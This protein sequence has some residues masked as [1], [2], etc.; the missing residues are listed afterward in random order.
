MVNGTVANNTTK[1]LNV[2]EFR[3]FALVDEKAPLIFINGADSWNAKFFSLLHEAAHIW[4]GRNDLYNDYEGDY[5]VGTDNKKI[6]ILCNKAASL[7]IASNDMFDLEW[8]HVDCKDVFET[9]TKLANVFHCSTTVIAR[10]ALDT[11]LITSHDYV[12]IAKTAKENYEMFRAKK[13]GGN[14]YNSQCVKLDR[15]FIYALNASVR[16][17][18]TSYTEAF[19]LTNTNGK[20]FARIVNIFED[21]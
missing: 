19:R 11:G 2:R 5:T 3:A 20:T 18:K 15:N 1:V 16:E 4:L 17:G 14:F 13:G 10:R 21:R 6:E 8:N 9:V 7:L 12:V